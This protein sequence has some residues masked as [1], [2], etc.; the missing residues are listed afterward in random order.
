ML[1]STQEE[2]ADED[3]NDGYGEDFET[4]QPEEDEAAGPGVTFDVVETLSERRAAARRVKQEEN[5]QARIKRA[6]VKLQT[7]ERHRQIAETEAAA[8]QRWELAQVEQEKVV[9]LRRA[10]RKRKVAADAARE[11]KHA[12]R[13]ARASA[14]L[15]GIAEDGA[16]RR[17]ARAVLAA[18]VLR[19]SQKEE[20]AAAVA[21][22]EAAAERAAAIA[23]WEESE[24][25]RV[26]KMAARENRKAA[27]ARVAATRAS[28]KHEE[29][30]GQKK[31]EKEERERKAA[32]KARM[33]DHVDARR[34]MEER[35]GVAK[36][37]MRAAAAQEVRPVVQ[38]QA[39]GGATKPVAPVSAE[40]KG[41][42]QRAADLLSELPPPEATPEVDEEEREQ[43]ERNA[44]NIEFE[45]LNESGS[46]LTLL[47][48]TIISHIR[49]VLCI[50]LEHVCS[51]EEELPEPEQQSAL[52]KRLLELEEDGSCPVESAAALQAAMAWPERVAEQRERAAAEAEAEAAAEDQLRVLTGQLAT[53]AAERQ[54]L[55]A[56]AEG[57]ADAEGVDLGQEDG[58]EPAAEE[59]W[60]DHVT[61]MSSKSA[62]RPSSTSSASASRSVS[63]APPRVSQRPPSQLAAAGGWISPLVPPVLRVVDTN[64][65]SPAGVAPVRV[66][67]STEKWH[68]GD[69][70]VGELLSA[71]RPAAAE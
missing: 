60:D 11:T 61:L 70:S 3:D 34:L 36:A 31:E 21:V 29:R 15:A 14:A 51:T 48:Y 10:E 43:M 23:R 47:K 32:R 65:N 50:Q 38:E 7:L 8:I 26:K 39:P 46:I 59:W 30:K 54:A 56:E 22:A 2:P 52:L 24:L 53:I 66:S 16:K 27:A 12:A 62:A 1:N 13:L 4:L 44:D 57:M 18:R 42:R 19:E 40:Q 25:A 58:D 9:A 45:A 71:K 20:E 37:E 55:E 17:K 64:E 35:W 68:G 49:S 5:A 33:R 69:A 41:L 6:Q 28:R 63:W 67:R